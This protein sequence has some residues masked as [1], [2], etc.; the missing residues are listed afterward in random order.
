M[1]AMIDTHEEFNR[2]KAAGFDEAG[3]AAL[4]DLHKRMQITDFVTK[5]EFSEFKGEMREFRDETREEFKAVRSELSDVKVLIQSVLTEQRTMQ[6]MQMRWM[7]GL[8]TAMLGSVVAA[9]ALLP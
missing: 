6:V 4:V 9:A 1:N 2:L 7:L 3:A 8:G 5:S